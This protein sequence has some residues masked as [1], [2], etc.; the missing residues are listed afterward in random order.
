MRTAGCRACSPHRA[1]QR[2]HATESSASSWT[3]TGVSTPSPAGTSPHVSPTP[4]S[5]ASRR[6]YASTTGA[7]ILTWL[8]D[9]EFGI[10]G[11]L[12]QGGRTLA[13][14]ASMGGNGQFNRLSALDSIVDE[15]T[16]GPWSDVLTEDQD[17]GLRLIHQ[18]W[19]GEQELRASVDQQGVS[20]L[21]RLLRQR[22]RW[23]QGNLQAM[24]HAGDAVRTARPLAVRVDL[25]ASILMPVLIGLLA[26]QFVASLVLVVLGATGVRNLDA[27]DLV[28]L[29]VLA[30]GPVL[31]G[32]VARGSLYGARGILLGILIAQVFAFYI[33]LIWPIYLRAAIRYVLG[34][35]SWQK[36][37][38]EP[39]ADQSG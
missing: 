34:R 19:R 6:S 9:V 8:Q 1:T 27:L 31:I 25:V 15:K 17:L 18:G 5:A 26:V 2:F 24:K 20:D 13:G 33:Y 32:C 10:Y 22:T 21:R 35:E 14:T 16:G 39:I 23:A 38:R 3:P 12:F 29:Y 28:V 11:A 36:T 37:S 30:F 7:A 4:V